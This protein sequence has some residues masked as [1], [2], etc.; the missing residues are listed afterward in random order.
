MEFWKFPLFSSSNIVRWLF[1]IPGH[2][3]RGLSDRRHR[4]ESNQCFLRPLRWF[5]DGLRSNFEKRY[6]FL[7]CKFSD[8]DFRSP[9]TSYGP[10]LV[11]GTTSSQTGTSR[12]RW[13][14]FEIVLRWFEM[15]WHGFSSNYWENL[16]NKYWE[17]KIRLLVV[18]LWDGFNWVSL[19]HQNTFVWVSCADTR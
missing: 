19:S 3:A 15:V 13:D 8:G 1:S 16:K 17:P 12:D 4:Q 9:N 2:I 6:C 10:L 11:I 5:W 14:G 18:I 7:T